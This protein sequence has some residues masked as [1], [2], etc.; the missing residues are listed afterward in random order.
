[1]L[2]NT[3]LS[4]AI[5]TLA[6]ETEAN[7]ISPAYLA[8]VLRKI[9]DLISSAYSSAT[10]LTDKAQTAAADAGES[11][12]AAQD[13]ANTAVAMLPTCTLAELDDLCTYDVIKGANRA[14]YFVTTSGTA[15]LLIGRCELFSDNMHHQITQV[16]TTH[17]TLTDEGKITGGSHID[18]E[19]YVYYRSYGLVN[20][21]PNPYLSWSAWKRID[22]ATQTA[23]TTL[24]TESKATAQAL[25]KLS[26][27]LATTTSNGL[28]SATDKSNLT[29]VYFMGW[30]TS[31]SAAYDAAATLAVCTPKLLYNQIC[32]NVNSQGNKELPTSPDGS[33]I[34]GSGYIYQ[35]FYK[36]NSTK[37]RIWQVMPCDGTSGKRYKRLLIVDDAQ[38]TV[39]SVESWKEF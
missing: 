6:A 24:E 34:Y 15:Q 14:T 4:Q 29:G 28:M 31:L 32:F 30:F 20:G 7:A 26:K 33:S 3:E 12:R 21:R 27:T 23:L 9:S 17:C 8:A 35:H 36:D 2:D 11:A 38:T 25:T 39:E 37:W 5:E 13:T 19:V 10:D 1:M 22:N 18:T 16:F